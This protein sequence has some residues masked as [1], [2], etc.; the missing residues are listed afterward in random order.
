MEKI[1]SNAIKN[2]TK[3]SSID[4]IKNELRAECKKVDFII[5]TEDWNYMFNEIITR[6]S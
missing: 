1:I 6:L 4:D 2:L 3:Q 5:D